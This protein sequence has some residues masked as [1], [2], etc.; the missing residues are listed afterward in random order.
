ARE[1]LTRRA[2]V[3]AMSATAACA[4]S[5]AATATIKIGVCTRDIA[6]AVRYGF[7]YIEPAAAEIAAMPEA[8]F[9]SFAEI[10]QASPIRC[11]AFNG[12]IRRPELK[13]VGNDVSFP[14][15]HDYLD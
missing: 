5:W 9:R 11:E 10:V 7:D 13:V 3:A 14:A 4:R 2:F 6:G 12:L 1:M 15:L 8:Q